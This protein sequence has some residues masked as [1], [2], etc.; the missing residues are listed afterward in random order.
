M[1]TTAKSSNGSRVRSSCS[2]CYLPGEFGPD[3]IRK[4]Q[5]YRGVWVYITGV[6]D[7]PEKYAAHATKINERE[8]AR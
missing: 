6:I 3:M 7:T 5:V 8:V 2:D 4:I 1:S